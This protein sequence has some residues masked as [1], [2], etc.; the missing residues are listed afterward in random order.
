MKNTEITNENLQWYIN[1]PVEIQ[2]E[3]FK[4]Y[5]NMAKVLANQFFEDEVRQKA[6]EKYTREKPEEGRYDRWGSNPVSIRV[7]EEKVKVKVPRL[8][9]NQQ[10]GTV[11]LEN[12][13]KLR[14]IPLPSE[15]LL[16]KIIIGLSQH[17]YKQVVQMAADSFVLSQSTVS[18]AF[19]EE[20]EK[21]LKVFEERDLGLYDF[22]ALVIDGKYNSKDNIVI[23]LG[24]TI[25]GDKIPLGFIQTTTE[26]SE[27]VSGLL[28][29]LIKRNFR[30]QEGILTIIDGSKGLKK[31][32]EETFGEFTLTQ[33]YQWHKRENVI[34][35]LPEIGTR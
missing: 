15:E 31:A 14:Q 13:K 33:R 21:A 10:E 20:S 12:Y 19:V 24:I 3:L 23:A 32:I 8:Y 2:L 22:I 25:N 26:N 16:K 5:V 7:G 9:D 18:R 17:D 1:Q 6:G 30:F 11:G 4:H 29:N 28:K 35:Y 34:S 27:A